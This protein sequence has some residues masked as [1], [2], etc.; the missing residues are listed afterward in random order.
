[1]SNT[2]QHQDAVSSTSSA[3]AI[4]RAAAESVGQIVLEN[5]DDSADLQYAYNVLARLSENGD[6]GASIASD[7][8]VASAASNALRDICHGDSFKAGWWINHKTG[9]DARDNPMCFSQKLCLIH[10]EISEAMEGDRKSLQDTH[11]PHRSMR[12]VELADALIRIFDLA[13][14]YGMDIG[15]ALAEK[16][17]YNRNRLDHKLSARSAEGG[18]AY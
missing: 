6:A 7:L 14:A 5:E 2:E 12:E 16:L 9:A 18:K 3:S 1:M 4:L 11:L 10:S 15:G 8:H 13:G 17:E